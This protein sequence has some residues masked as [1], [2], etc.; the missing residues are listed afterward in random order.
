M[1]DL[2]ATTRFAP[3]RPGARVVGVRT[4]GAGFTLVELLIV[5]SI[6]AVALVAILPAFSRVIESN[7]YAAAVNAVT[8]TLKRAAATGKEGGVVFS[9]D[10]QTQVCSLQQVELHLADA[11]L[12]E[13]DETNNVRIPAA[14]YRPVAGVAPV[15]LPRGVA[16]YGLSFSHEDYSTAGGFPDAARWYDR[17]AVF[18]GSG[19]NAGRVAINPWLFPR[20]HIQ[21]SV[22]DYKPNNPQAWQ[23]MLG[24]NSNA[25]P[26][27]YG[28]GGNIDQMLWNY[29]QTFFV[30]FGPGGVA[31]G[32][33]PGAGPKDAYVEF[34]GL[35]AADVP[36][37]ENL[38][39]N[40]AERDD[41]FD[42]AMFYAG[43]ASHGPVTNPEVRMRPVDQLAIVDLEALRRGTGIDKPWYARSNGTNTPATPSDKQRYRSDPAA[44]PN[45]A[46]PGLVDINRWIDANGQVIGFGRFSGQVVKR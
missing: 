12:Y 36:V 5:I 15:E 2:R 31:T 11:T 19:A 8:A 29:A 45:P 27:E 9:F 20:T 35:P 39:G 28:S 41:R 16:V 14:A 30:R 3:R 42:P 6:I 24:A 4:G 23:S 37:G 43:D 10:P 1:M 13:A 26:S 33:T 25:Q 38:P 32:S 22:T 46:S 40:G 21:F 17:E 18:F 7:N 34:P 44:Q